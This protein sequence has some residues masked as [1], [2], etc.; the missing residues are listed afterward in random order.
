MRS[1]FNKFVLFYRS[2]EF[3]SLHR[4]HLFLVVSLSVSL[5]VFLSL[6]FQF[7]LFEWGWG[8]EYVALVAPIYTTPICDS[9]IFLCNFMLMNSGVVTRGKLVNIGI[10]IYYGGIFQGSL[11]SFCN[12]RNLLKIFEIFGI[13]LESVESQR[14]I[15]NPVWISGIFLESSESSQNLWF[16]KYFEPLESY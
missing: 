10:D 8:T 13:I 14:T 1:R 16:P 12:L 2:Q 5:S 15:Q 3:C 9:W 7:C 4:G 11:K 6:S